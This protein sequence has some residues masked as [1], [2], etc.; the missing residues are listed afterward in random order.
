MREGDQQTGQS[1]TIAPTS[2]SSLPAPAATTV[3]DESGAKNEVF[4]YPVLARPF[5]NRIL[6][7]ATD[8]LASHASHAAED[9]DADG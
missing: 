9:D 2:S 6:I 4:V 3:T 7:A 5:M 1:E 8:A